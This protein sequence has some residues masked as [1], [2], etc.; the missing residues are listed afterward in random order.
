MDSIKTYIDDLMESYGNEIEVVESNYTEI[1]LSKVPKVLQ[2]FY[3][4]YKNVDLPFGYIYSIETAMEHSK[5][6]PFDSEGWFCFGQDK[7]FSFWLCKYQ[8]DE[9]NLSFTSWDHES[10][11]EIDGV[12][13][14]TL[15]EFL[16]DMQSEY[17][18]YEDLE[19]E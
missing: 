18:E 11:I 7:Y 6:E 9:E 2:N 17:E 16:Q 5:A 12:V 13:Y 10:G 3:A 14:E 1:D 15:E 4:Q 8:P 19:E